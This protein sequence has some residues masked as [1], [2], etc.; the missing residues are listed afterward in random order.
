MKQEPVPVV[1]LTEAEAKVV[2]G[3]FSQDVRG[4]S[5]KG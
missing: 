3:R 2:R 5:S 4:A 1:P